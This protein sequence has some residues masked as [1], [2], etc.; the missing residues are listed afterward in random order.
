MTNFL[1]ESVL[2]GPLPGN[3][4][5]KIIMKKV[6]WLHQETALSLLCYQTRTVQ[7]IPISWKLFCLPENCILYDNNGL[8]IPPSRLGW[9][10]RL[11]Q[12]LHHHHHLIVAAELSVIIIEKI[13]QILFLTWEVHSPHSPPHL[14]RA[15]ESWGFLFGTKTERCEAEQRYS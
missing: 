4:E 3:S 9:Q 1:C 12:I 15:P 8:E 11:L 7:V 14:P 5:L 13:W 6:I 10:Y 2:R